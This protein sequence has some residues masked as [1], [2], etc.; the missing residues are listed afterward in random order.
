[1]ADLYH[2]GFESY[3]PAD[4]TN[5]LK[6]IWGHANDPAISTAKYKTGSQCLNPTTGNPARWYHTSDI[7][8]NK[9]FVNFAFLFTDGP[10]LGSIVEFMSIAGAECSLKLLPNGRVALYRGSTLIISG[11]EKLY[12]NT[13]YY[14][15][16]KVTLSDSTS[17]G[18]CIVKIN[19]VTDI[20]IGTTEDTWD[21]GGA[22]CGVSLCGEGPTQNSFFDDVSLLDDTGSNNNTFNGECAVES[23]R[24]DGNGTTSQW[25]G[26]DGNQVDNYLMIDD[27][28]VGDTAEY[29]EAQAA[30]EVDLFTYENL[31]LDV[32]GV[33]A[34]KCVS[35]VE[36]TAAGPRT[37]RAKCRSNGTNYDG[38]TETMPE[39]GYRYSHYIWETDPDTSSLWLEAAVNAAEFGVEV[40]A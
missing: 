34:V 10:E 16:V 8:N 18:D 36:K 30:A 4:E 28:Y 23:R 35:L 6:R 29:I 33:K 40:V 27:Q 15:E 39:G 14:L 22:L 3:D 37:I 32:L 5:T 11:S 21:T 17:A 25:D 7:T 26:S 19:E 24:P 13:W 31:A 38:D 2:D 12:E 9:L 1:M 20:T